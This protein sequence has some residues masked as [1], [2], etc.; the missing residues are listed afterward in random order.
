MSETHETA[1]ALFR[2][3]RLAPAIEA[4]NA[5]AAQ[6]PDRSRRRVL[7][8]ELLLFAGN[9]ERAD[10]ILDAAA[11]LD[12]SAMV[13][14]AEFRQLL[15]AD[16]ARR[17]LRRDGR[18]PEFLGDPTPALRASLAAFVA[19]R[20]GDGAEAARQ[21]AEVETLRPRAGGFA[22]ETAFED[23]RDVDDLSRRLLRGADDDRQIFLDTDRAGRQHGASR[24]AAAARSLLAARQRLGHRRP[25]RRCLSAGHLR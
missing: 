13:A 22:G 10:T 6:E 3:G 8:A 20:A 25:R 17:Q 4:A 19:W 15:R 24:A 16:L 21:I 14:I 9:F 11:E 2:A 5:G 7:L 12:P 23:F 18:V 1:G